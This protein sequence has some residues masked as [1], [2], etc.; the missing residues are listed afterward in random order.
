MPDQF[1]LLLPESQVSAFSLCKSTFCLNATG[2]QKVALDVF[3]EWSRR[4]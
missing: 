4:F 2:D 1:S 3:L